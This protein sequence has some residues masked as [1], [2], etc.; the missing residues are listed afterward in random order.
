MHKGLDV[1][2]TKC[3]GMNYLEVCTIRLYEQWNRRKFE[4]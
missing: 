2:F 4:L 1:A 3:N